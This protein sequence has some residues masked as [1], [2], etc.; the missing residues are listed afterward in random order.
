MA[1]VYQWKKTP[2]IKLII[3]AFLGVG[4]SIGAIVILNF[5]LIQFNIIR[6]VGPERVTDVFGTASGISSLAVVVLGLLGG[7]IADKTRLKF[8]RRRF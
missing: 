2:Y 5:G 7:V 3:A 8:G 1:H 4:T 6:L